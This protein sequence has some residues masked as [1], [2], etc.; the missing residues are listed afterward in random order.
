MD[1]DNGFRRSPQKPGDLRLLSLN[2]SDSEGLI[3]DEVELVLTF[4]LGTSASKTPQN[5]RVFRFAIL[6][7][8]FQPTDTLN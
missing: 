5:R 7:V 8:P 2:P 3:G 4:L 6:L 1:P